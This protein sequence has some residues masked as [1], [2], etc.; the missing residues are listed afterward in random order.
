MTW[1]SLLTFTIQCWFKERKPNIELLTQIASSR[2][3]EMLMGISAVDQ[4]FEYKDI[5]EE[6]AKDIS[7]VMDRLI[8]VIFLTIFFICTAIGH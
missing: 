8:F 5:E 6:S 1:A 4:S 2:W 7:K 3:I